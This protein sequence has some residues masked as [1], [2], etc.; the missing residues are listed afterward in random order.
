MAQQLLVQRNDK[1]AVAPL[2][3]LAAQ[4]PAPRTQLHALWTLDGMDS[5]DP[6]SVVRALAHPSRDVRVAALRLSERWLREGNPAVQTAV[7]ALVSDSD[8]AIR[9]QLGA[10][11]GELPRA[12][13]ETAMVTFLERHGG[14]PVAVDAALSGL[15]GS[16][17]A[18]L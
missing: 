5:L 1:A 12:A 7:L 6:A 4:A 8:W 10:S 11:L 2:A 14:D 3:K 16:E 18:V 9:E 15:R 17:A 13:K